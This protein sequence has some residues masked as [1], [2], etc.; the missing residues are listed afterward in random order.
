M[1][2]VGVRLGTPSN[3]MSWTRIVLSITLLQTFIMSTLSVP[4]SQWEPSQQFLKQP[5]DNPV[6]TL[7]VPNST[8]SFWLNTPGANPLANE[9]SHG[10]LTTDADICIIGSGI[11]GVSTA[12]H[13]A[14]QLDQVDRPIKTVILEAREFCSLSFS[15]MSFNGLT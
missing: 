7:P 5:S 14:K 10:P 15:L 6:A 1:R 12:Y 4:V 13:L 8:Q 3:E 9:G 11:T 2:Q